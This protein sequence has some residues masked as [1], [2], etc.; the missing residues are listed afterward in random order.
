MEQSKPKK[1]IKNG[2]K[3]WKLGEGLYMIDTSHMIWN[4]PD[5]RELIIDNEEIII[6]RK[7]A[8]PKDTSPQDSN[9]QD[10]EETTTP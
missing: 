8:Q 5:Y 2:K 7:D 3:C 1:V 10:K 9:T 4:K 6:T